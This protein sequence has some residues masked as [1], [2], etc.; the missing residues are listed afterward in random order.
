MSWL[1]NL[2]ELLLGKNPIKKR[3]TTE[4]E[5]GASATLNEAA[6]P[7]SAPKNK[8]NEDFAASARPSPGDAK[9]APSSATV[10]AAGLASP[11]VVVLVPAFKNDRDAGFTNRVMETLKTAQMLNV[12][13]MEREFKSPGDRPNAAK[14]VPFQVEVRATLEEQSAD[15]LIYGEVLRNGLRMRL[16]SAAPPAEGRLG[17]FGIGDAL[18]VPHNFGSE[19]ANLMYA[20]VLT[21]ALPA[22]PNHHD[23]LVP[24]LVGAAEQSMKLL[25]SVPDSIDP[26]Q[27]GAVFTCLGVVCGAVW[28][29]QKTSRGLIA[30]VTAFEKASKEGPGELAPLAMAELKTRLGIALQELSVANSD[31]DMFEE[32]LDAFETVTS[33]LDPNKYAREWG[34]AYLCLGNAFLLRGKTEL[35]VDDCDRASA[36]FDAALKVFTKEKDKPRWLEV[37]TAK[38]AALMTAGAINTGTKELEAATEVLREVLQ[39]RDRVSQPLP[40]AQAS[41]GLGSAVFALAKRTQNKAQLEEAIT[42]FDGAISIYESLNQTVA[43][44]IVS[45]NQQRAYRLRETIGG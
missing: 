37:M 11:A 2:I 28:R 20:S 42:C 6:E 27:T 31:A 17:E 24:H 38:G 36:A 26:E 10:D 44:G 18:M 5:N 13:S 32:A 35:S 43:I 30:A 19:L 16:V 3:K 45:K 12:G 25:E 14:L 7:N 40:W 22:K 29:L 41:N 39:E 15:L 21:A 8:P 4:A 34:L 23:A 1:T 33:A 9:P